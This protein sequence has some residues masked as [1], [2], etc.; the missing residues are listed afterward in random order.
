MSALIRLSAALSHSTRRAVHDDHDGAKFF[1]QGDGLATVLR[2]ADH[3]EV[4]FEFEH[5]AKTLAHD[6]VVFGQQDG[7]SFLRTCLKS[8]SRRKALTFSA[9]RS[10][11]P[12]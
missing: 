2:F 6:C 11:K 7:D 12:G 5:L 1:D 4:V 9:S 8:S 10:G 3:F